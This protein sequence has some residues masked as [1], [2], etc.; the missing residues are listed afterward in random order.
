MQS[1]KQLHLVPMRSFSCCVA[2]RMPY[3]PEERPP[4]TEQQKKLYPQ[5]PQTFTEEGYPILKVHSARNAFLDYSKD[6]RPRRQFADLKPREVK[7]KENQDWPSI[8]PTAKTF[9]P[10]AVP[11]PLRQSYEKKQ[12]NVPRGK[13]AN[14]ELLKIQNFLHLTPNAIKRHCE[15]LKKFCTEWPEQLNDHEK[16]REYF[17]ITY[18]TSD[19]VHSGPSIRDPR[20]RIVKLIINI[21]DLKLDPDDEEKLIALAAH[22]YNE[23]THELTITASACPLRNQNMDYADYLLT[24]VYSESKARQEWEKEKPVVKEFPT[25]LDA[26]RAEIEQRLGFKKSKIKAN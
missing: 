24:A 18:V 1:L 11:L 7:M 22:R 12:T 14:T 9:V 16:A 19:Y 20:A 3:S 5:V 17:P 13:Y 8:W 6:R 4:M 10:S 26:Y 2:S 15:A 23:E 21:K 25:D